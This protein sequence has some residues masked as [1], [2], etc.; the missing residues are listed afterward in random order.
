MPY[1]IVI[2]VIV[3]VLVLGGQRRIEQRLERLERTLGARSVDI[4]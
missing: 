2:L 4:D 3:L 1:L